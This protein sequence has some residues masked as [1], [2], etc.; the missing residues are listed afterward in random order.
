MTQEQAIKTLI[1]AVEIAQQKGA[2][3]LK[4]V[5]QVLNAI[6]KLQTTSS[7]EAQVPEKD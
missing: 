4:D 6:V 2:Y 3:T 7:E 1:S 5:A